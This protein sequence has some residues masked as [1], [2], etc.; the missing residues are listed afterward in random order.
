MLL[1]G[2]IIYDIHKEGGCGV[3]KFLENLQT[4]VDDFRGGRCGVCVWREGILF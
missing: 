2:V 1:V 4:I 3:M